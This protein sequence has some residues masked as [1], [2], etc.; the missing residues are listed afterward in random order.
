MAS[1]SDGSSGQELACDLTRR[2]TLP[3]SA[4][5]RG[6]VMAGSRDCMDSGRRFNSASPR[7]GHAATAGP[8]RQPDSHQRPRVAA[9]VPPS[10]C[11]GYE[12]GLRLR[13][14]SSML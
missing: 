10:C 4:G 9:Q 2:A 3:L 7:H 5:Q 6:P 11:P 12:R 8:V 13:L 14:R 1:G